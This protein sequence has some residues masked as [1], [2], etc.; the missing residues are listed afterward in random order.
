MLI[1]TQGTD[2]W[3]RLQMGSRAQLL[4]NTIALSAPNVINP[5]VSFALIFVISRS[6]GAQGLGEY[7]LIL[8]WQAIFATVA[9]MGL[10]ALVIRETSRKPETIHIF[11]SNAMIFGLVSSTLAVIAMLGTVEFMDYPHRIIVGATISSLSLIPSTAIRYVEAAFRSVEKS[12]YIALCYMTENVVRVLASVALL[13]MG[14]DLLWVFGAITL[15]NFVTVLLMMYFYVRI[16]GRPR[17][18]F[19]WE[20]WKLMTKQSPTFLSIAILSTLHLSMPEIMLSKLLNIEAVGI[21][22]AAARVVGFAMV[23]P[24]GFCMALLPALTK[25]YQ[26]GLV[27][28]HAMTSDSVRYAFIFI[29]PIIIG[30]TILS[31]QIIHIIYGDK[32]SDAVPALRLMVF[33]VAPYFVLVSL[34]QV[35]VS[36]DN[37]AFDLKVNLV[38][39]IISF[40][41]HMALVPLLGVMGSILAT[42]I[43]FIILNQM[44]YGF[45]K[46]KL[47]VLDFWSLSFKPLLATA[48]MAPVTLLLCDYNI[49][50]NVL[51]SAIIYA[52]AI[53]VLKALTSEEIIHIL[54]ILR[55]KTS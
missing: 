16:I 5:F 42:I 35:L 29:F 55:K 28:L 23:I 49:L 53:I 32:F 12:E 37:Q 48:L 52:I 17:W 2:L 54:N 10:S 39:V 9:S 30:T 14:F 43:C 25:K 31:D 21:F 26:D 38:A 34:A 6:L 15:I 19:D 22:S 41:L 13:L 11:F 45:M 8:A 47:F 27:E 20:I 4:K 36:T 1:L 18:N 50:I 46:K 33:G 24:I 7:S 51:F 40:V 44:Q 3:K